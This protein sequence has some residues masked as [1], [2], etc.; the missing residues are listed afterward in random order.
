[1]NE[2]FHKIRNGLIVSCQS[3][4]DDPFNTIEGVTA[5][6]KAAFMG[7]AVAIRS[8]G[9]EK[10]KSIKASVKL[11]IIGLLKSTF[12]DGYVKITGSFSEV[13]KLLE[14]GCDIIA[15]DGTFRERDHFNGPDFIKELKSRYSCIIM[16]DIATVNEAIAC[17]NSGADCISSTLN[18]YT[19]DTMRNSINPNFDIIKQLVHKMKIPV[20]AE[21]KINTPIEARKM[22]E[23]GVWAVVA[24]TAITRPRII[25][26]WYINE[27]KKVKK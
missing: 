26:Q 27:M 17:E 20:I 25:T 4:G 10:I 9:V 13:E 22:L 2:I 11:P 18:G 21:G 3:E 14:I 16:A 15:V 5:F 12:P 7:G 6:A 23:Y 24:G 8:E 19:P 1:M